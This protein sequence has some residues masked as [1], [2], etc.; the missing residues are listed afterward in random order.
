MPFNRWAA[1]A[2]EPQS[3]DDMYADMDLAF[4]EG[5]DEALTK[6]LAQQ[7]SRETDLRPSLPPEEEIRHIN[8]SLEVAYP[9]S[10]WESQRCA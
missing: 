9:S 4:D 1:P 6:A 8:S 10:R 7:K 5:D 2:D 3:L